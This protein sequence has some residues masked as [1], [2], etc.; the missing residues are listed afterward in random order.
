MRLHG[1]GTSLYLFWKEEKVAKSPVYFGV[2][3]RVL[4][5]VVKNLLDFSI[6]RS[7]NS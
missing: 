5:Q 3:L 4:E 6:K 1:R 7:A 2:C